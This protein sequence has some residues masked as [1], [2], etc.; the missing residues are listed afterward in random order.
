MKRHNTRPK[1]RRDLR[2]SNR[3]VE[4][5][6]Y[7]SS[8]GRPSLGLL[9]SSCQDKI[10]FTTY[11]RSVAP[12]SRH[13]RGLCPEPL[14]ISRRN[15]AESFAISPVAG[16]FDA[17]SYPRSQQVQVDPSQS[18]D[19]S[20]V[21]SPI[22][23]R[24]SPESW[25][26]SCDQSNNPSA[27]EVG[28][29]RSYRGNHDIEH[30][31]QGR[32]LSSP[33][34]VLSDPNQRAVVGLHAN[35]DIFESKQD[36]CIFAEAICGLDVLEIFDLSGTRHSRSESLQCVELEGSRDCREPKRCVPLG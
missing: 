31:P 23:A 4:T 16:Q 28:S 19:Y 7:P 36:A 17:I 20:T 33:P 14:V 2:D 1:Q 34:H 27:K 26:K 12:L 32:S 9:P 6:V 3:P 11:L 10:P 35:V 15:V 18:S 13:Q 24:D 22:S 30:S 21:Y 5:S 25:S 29:P 8:C